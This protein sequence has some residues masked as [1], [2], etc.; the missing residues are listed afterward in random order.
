MVIRAAIGR[1]A[2]TIGIIFVMGCA[3]GES[4]SIE[5]E[6]PLISSNTVIHIDEQTE[7]TK[8]QTD[9]LEM[10]TQTESVAVLVNRQFPLPDDF[11]PMDL[12]YP[13]VPFLFEE[14]IEKRMLRKEAAEALEQLFSAAKAD[15]IKLIGVSAYRSHQTQTS[16]FNYYV[17]KDGEEV[18]K[19]YSAVPGTS[20]HETGLA[21]DVTGGDGACAAEACF[22]GTEEA[23]WLKGN[24]ANY[25][26]I[27][28]YPEGKEEITGYVYEP[29]HIR[30][31]GV[32][33]AKEITEQGLTLEEYYQVIPVTNE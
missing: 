2:L 1:Y 7:E 13:D 5:Q 16:L 23:K 18:A 33:L 24:V 31:V 10:A 4:G 30:Y 22:A 9:L 8:E 21:I 12:I 11:A 14:K 3:S 17:A 15:G 6:Q 20:E 26:Y 32:D 29:W 25:G 27:I 19:T 28:R